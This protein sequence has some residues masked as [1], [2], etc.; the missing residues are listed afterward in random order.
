MRDYQPH[1]AG[2]V[3]DFAGSVRS[4]ADPD[5]LA[6]DRDAQADARDRAAEAR[7]ERADARDEQA[8]ARDRAAG[9]G[10]AGAAID[11]AAALRD[12][13]ASAS[14]RERASDDRRTAS[15]DRVRSAR[16]RTAS[17]IDGLTG[18]LHR[19]A[20]IVELERDMA[21]ARRT[22]QPFALVFVD[23]IG[24]KDT[25]D[26]LGHAAGDWLLR[27]TS[28]SIRA[29]LRSYDVIVRFGGDEFVCGLLGMTLADAAARLSLV[30]AD[31]ARTQQTAI[32]VGLAELRAGDVLSDLVARADDAMY[33]ARQQQRPDRG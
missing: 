27:E 14:D 5:R 8:E 25:N 11:R 24:L 26:S 20:G 7:D 16:E 28:E 33:K 13:V 6:N 9:V 23:V 3:R 22:D 15:S 21:R 17:S 29:R 18:A 30:S 19:E 10:G 31:L 2:K 1:N 32:T 12:R 4:G